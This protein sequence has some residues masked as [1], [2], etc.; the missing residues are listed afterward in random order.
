MIQLDLGWVNLNYSISDRDEFGQNKSS[1]DSVWTV[2][3]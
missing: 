2:F 3:E 1:L